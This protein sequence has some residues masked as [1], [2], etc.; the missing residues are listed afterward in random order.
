[1]AQFTKQLSGLLIVGTIL[2]AACKS[3]EVDPKYQLG[4]NESA[5][6]GSEVIVRV[7]SIQDSRCPNDPGINCITGGFASVRLS[8]NKGNDLQQRRLYVGPDGK[9]Y[10]S[11]S[12]TIS[13]S[14]L[15]YRIVLKDVV[16]Q[17]SLQNKSPD[18]EAVLQISKL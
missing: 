8:I 7:D 17:P 11:D 3:S 18:K 6:L 13:F 5:R 2:F 9:R 1:M 10:G 14:N 16:P 12:T 15:T 4:Q